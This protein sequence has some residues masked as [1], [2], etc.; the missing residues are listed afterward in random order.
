MGEGGRVLE[1]AEGRDRQGSGVDLHC[2]LRAGPGEGEPS[3]LSR[4]VYV[5]EVG[6]LQDIGCLP[7]P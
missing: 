7:G 1:E 4:G 3:Q 2:E 6:K 5:D